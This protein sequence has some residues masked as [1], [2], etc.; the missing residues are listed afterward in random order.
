M[1]FS[2]SLSLCV[3]FDVSAGLLVRAGGLARLVAMA[4]CGAA[5][6]GGHGRSP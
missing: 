4:G 2:C 5:V 6:G 1:L 3:G